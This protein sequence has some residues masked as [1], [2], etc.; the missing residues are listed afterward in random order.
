MSSELHG[1]L[2]DLLLVRLVIARQPEDHDG[3]GIGLS[4]AEVF[5]DRVIDGSGAEAVRDHPV[6]DQADIED[7]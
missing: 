4:G 3:D 7:A 6:V 1:N 5:A 2:M